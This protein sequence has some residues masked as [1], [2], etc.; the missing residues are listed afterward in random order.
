MNVTNDWKVNAAD[1]QG[2]WS[3][4]EEL[5]SGSFGVV[6]KAK[7]RGMDVAIKRIETNVS[8][9]KKKLAVLML[10]REVRTLTR[11]HHPNVVRLMGACSDPPMLVL[12][13]A[14]QGTLY[15]LLHQDNNEP[16]L[17]KRK[18]ELITGILNGMTALHDTDI[19][20][21]DLKPANILISADG[22]PWVSDFG[23][24]IRT[25]FSLNGGAKSTK[26]GRGTMQYKAPEYFAAD[27]S[28]D[29]DDDDNSDN[30]TKASPKVT[31]QPSADVYS[32]GVVC[33]EILTGKVPFADKTA[34][35]I[36]AAHIRALNG[37]KV[38]R[39]SLNNV[40]SETIPLIKACWAQ[41]PSARPTFRVAKDMLDALPI[42]DLDTKLN[43]CFSYRTAPNNQPPPRVLEAKVGLEALGYS[44]FWGLDVDMMGPDWR[45]Q[46][47]LKCNEA[48]ICINFLSARY[49]QSQ[50]CVDEW[51]YVMKNNRAETINVALGGRACRNAIKALPTQGPGS[52][53]QQGGAGIKMHFTSDGQALSV[54]DEDNI[55]TKIIIV[56]S[57][58]NSNIIVIVVFINIII[59]AFIVQYFIP[60]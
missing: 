27:D 9:T 35:N 59:V 57:P 60:A 58:H 37:G 51:N 30:E 16:L 33:W 11:C 46:W 12:A 5:G 18:R 6:Y 45:N 32:F 53:A 26:G 22:T 13:Y 54:Y 42:Q 4:R 52:I 3:E 36:V 24:A 56:V 49:V 10:N 20:H 1:I 39:P 17:P 43:I 48:D 55:V 41:D 34:G 21:L 15:D 23:L 31:Y 19:L 29:D 14:S 28:D 7:L 44:V 25:T 50:A 8:A 2:M 38:K 47:M 40:P